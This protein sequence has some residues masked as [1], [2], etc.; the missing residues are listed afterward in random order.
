MRIFSCAS[1][2]DA[3]I[4]HSHVDVHR[5]PVGGHMSHASDFVAERN[6]FRFAVLR[7]TKDDHMSDT[8]QRQIRKEN[9][10]VEETTSLLEPNT[11]MYYA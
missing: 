5:C 8:S 7:G 11:L 6:S 4:L 10:Q 2:Y 1:R 3:S 9:A